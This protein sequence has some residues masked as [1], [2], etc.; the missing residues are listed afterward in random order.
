MND[1]APTPAAGNDT[2]HPPLPPE[3]AE[4]LNAVGARIHEQTKAI[5][6]ALP[7]DAR[8]AN[9]VAKEFKIEGVVARRLVRLIAGT[10]GLV[11]ITRMPSVDH[12]RGFANLM[13]FR[14]VE[15]ERCDALLEALDELQTEQRAVGGAKAR[16][17]K[18]VRATIA[19]QGGTSDDDG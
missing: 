10:P 15:P 19:A 17:T 7:E 16:L 14:G 12:Y 4:R 3:Q 5:F 8:T 2:R 11:S 18:R 9:A 6:E 1:H 13:K